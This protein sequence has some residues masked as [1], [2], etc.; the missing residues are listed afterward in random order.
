MVSEVKLNAL[1][2]S[3]KIIILFYCRMSSKYRQL[4]NPG[5]GMTDNCLVNIIPIGHELIAA[6]EADYVH[7]IDSK[8]LNSV[9]KVRYINSAC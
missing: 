4:R 5:E 7:Q 8:T 1:N 9:E 6:T 2:L 3:I